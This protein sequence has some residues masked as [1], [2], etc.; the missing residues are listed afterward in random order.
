GRTAFA[1]GLVVALAALVALPGPDV[2]GRAARR[3]RWVPAIALAAL[4]TLTSPVAALF[5]ALVALAWALVRRPVAWLAVGAAVPMAL[6]VVLF[7]E[8]G[9]MPDTWA[10]ARPVLLACLA[11]AVLCRG[12]PVRAGAVV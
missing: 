6:I 5:L 11:V 7:S 4:T 3:L 10:V 12:V 8:P 2:G 1:L 9:H